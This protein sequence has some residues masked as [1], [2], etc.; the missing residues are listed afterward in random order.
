MTINKPIFPFY[1]QLAINW[2]NKWKHHLRNRNWLGHSANQKADEISWD[3]IIQC[4][5]HL[6]SI[7]NSF[8]SQ[9]H[10]RL[11]LLT[12]EN[13]GAFPF[14]STE[15]VQLQ[16]PSWQ[17][18][19]MNESPNVSEACRWCSDRD[20]NSGWESLY[21]SWA[22]FEVVTALHWFSCPYSHEDTTRTWR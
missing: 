20:H 11:C 2:E 1:N 7:D 15:G 19:C 9:L 17:G 18:C 13:S 12:F 4:S 3:I 5:T 14:Q 6:L 16:I 21:F 22:D 8:S 10:N